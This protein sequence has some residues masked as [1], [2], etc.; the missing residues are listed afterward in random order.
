MDVIREP[1]KGGWSNRRKGLLAGGGVLAVAVM[2]LLVGL[3]PALPSV[4]AGTVL[5][6]TV[7]RGD[8]T[9]NLSGPGALVAVETRLIPSILPEAQV[10]QLLTQPGAVVKPDSV[11]LR[12]G[13]SLVRQQYDESKLRLEV[14]NAEL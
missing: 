9:R 10:E 5:V 13:N 4:P 11:L 7:K 1:R 8:M 2:F 3:G 6:D 12:L 14:A